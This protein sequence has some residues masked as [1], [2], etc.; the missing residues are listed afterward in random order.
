MR[1]PVTILIA[2]LTIAAAWAQDMRQVV[3]AAARAGRI[4]A[5][6]EAL[7]PLGSIGVNSDLESMSASPD[8]RTLYLAQEH[9][10]SC[11]G[12][13]ALNLETRAMCPFVSPALFGTPSPDNRL[14]FTQDGRHG[15][16]AFDAL[17]L[18]PVAFMKSGGA[19]NLQPSPDG[20][21]L[22][23]ITNSPAT[24]VDVFDLTVGTLV[25]RIG[26]PLGPA[27][28]IWAGNQF[29]VFSYGLPGVGQLWSV[30]PQDNRPHPARQ[31][32]LP[33]LHGGCNVPVLLMLAGAP[34]RLF[35]AEAYGFNVD[36]RRACPDAPG[37]I[38]GIDPA[39]GRVDAI[40]RSVHVNRLAVSRDS[41]DLYVIESGPA[42]LL[43]LDA[44][45]GRT[46]AAATLDAGDWSLALATIPRPLVP[47]GYVRAAA[48]FCR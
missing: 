44:R 30:N 4:E 47:R 12:L 40:A 11:C 23:G 14:V 15:V 29:Y 41:G 35:L 1:T 33:D 45:T 48:A 42:R 31:I 22:L 25:R 9:S 46:L 34:G 10:G 16:S 27:T 26:I 43:R 13:Y 32:Q 19:Y 21:W 7:Q 17:T 37:G 28:G 36:R 20:R 8:G 3:L 18:K 2:L 6:D 38:Y 24:S 5:Y 39:S